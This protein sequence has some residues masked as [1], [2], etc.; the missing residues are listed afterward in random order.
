M[1][2]KLLLSYDIKAH[3]M[4]DYYRFIMGE[5]LPRAQTVGLVM[6]EGWH[7]AYGDYPNRLLAFMAESDTAMEEA[8]HSDT[9]DSIETKLNEFVTRYEKRLVPARPSF[10]FFIPQYRHEG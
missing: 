7:T 8:L 5:F 6:T 10:Q 1:A 9:W 2:L 3:R 4:E